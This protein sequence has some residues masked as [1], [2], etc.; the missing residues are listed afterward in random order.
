MN[1]AAWTGALLSL[2]FIGLLLA[3]IAWLCAGERALNRAAQ[4]AC[5]E[6]TAPRATLATAERVARTALGER[7]PLGRRAQFVAEIRRP[8]EQPSGELDLRSGDAMTIRLSARGESIVP[9]WL[10]RW[11]LPL[12]RFWVVG[13]ATRKRP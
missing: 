11:G 9:T 7:S 3:Q 12:A 2:A 1:L 4:A 6:A 5:R 8:A 10:S 13:S